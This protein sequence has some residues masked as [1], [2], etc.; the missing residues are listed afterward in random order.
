[1]LFYHVFFVSYYKER[2]L[3]DSFIF[4]ES[5]GLLGLNNNVDLTFPLAFTL[6]YAE[7]VVGFHN[8][9]SAKYS[10]EFMKTYFDSLI[11]GNT[12][13]EAFEE[14]K[15]RNGAYDN[16]SYRGLIA[17]PI[18]K[19]NIAAVL[20][21]IGIHNHN[22]SSALNSWKKYGDVRVLSKL[23]NINTIGE[24][25]ER[26][27]VITTGIGSRTTGYLERGTEGSVLSQQF[28]V[29]ENALSLSFDYDFV[30]EEPLEYVGNMY[31]DSFELQLR[32]GTN[33]VF[34]KTYESIN[35][36]S[37]LY[38][39][40]I[41]FDDGDDTAYHTGWKKAKIDISEF[42]G[43]IVTISFI[44]IDEGDSFYDSACLIDNVEINYSS[45]I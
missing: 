13:Q 29:P 45:N 11:N 43:K 33:V 23:G 16:T 24:A 42:R 32:Y 7:A 2:E 8:Y 4:I 39:D 30:S 40:A 38:I 36:S 27:A 35:S 21:H 25:N 22:F 9:V 41:N 34:E 37:W 28:I 12:A 26:M 3:D 31:N 20:C 1:M 6:R 5:C 44:I 18:L 14:A 10:R 15:A 19:G 17:Y